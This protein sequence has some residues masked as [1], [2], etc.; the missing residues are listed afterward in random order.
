VNEDVKYMQHVITI[1]IGRSVT[2]QYRKDGRLHDV[3]KPKGAISLFPSQRPFFRR[4]GSGEAGASDFLYLALDPV[5]VSRTA[6]DLEFYP[7]RV[8]LIEKLGETDAALQ[9][10]ALALRSALQ[11]GGSGEKM[12]GES[13]G[14]ALAVHL[15][16]QYGGQPVEQP[17]A[18]GELSR[19]KLM[20][21]VDYI[22]DQL[23][24]DLSVAEIARA[25]HM[26]PFHFARLFKKTTGQSP[27]RYVI[28]A[29]AKRAKVLLKS[30]K[31]SISEVA[32][33]TGFADQRHLTHH[34]KKFYGVTPKMLQSQ[35]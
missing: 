22:E 25:V 30:R 28:E 17:I 33:Q 34:V 20:R 12:Y 31:F 23:H 1:N 3:T 13:L 32:H 18:P 26:S 24:E 29:R 7:N 8:E 2:A 27:Y 19:E 21:A 10:I 14:L 16:R 9:H 15:L 4:V 11:T 35:I 6:T 5:F